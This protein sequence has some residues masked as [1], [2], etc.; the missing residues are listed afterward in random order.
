MGFDLGEIWDE[1]VDYFGPGFVE[2]LV[3]NRGCEWCDGE[4]EGFGFD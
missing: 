3:P 4:V 1:V 2:R